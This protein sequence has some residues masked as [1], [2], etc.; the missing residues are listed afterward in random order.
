M[1][2]CILLGLGSDLVMVECS[3]LE[4]KVLVFIC[5][6]PFPLFYKRGGQIASH[7]L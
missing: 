7:G 2:G 5:N 6:S 3:I 1:G 4:P